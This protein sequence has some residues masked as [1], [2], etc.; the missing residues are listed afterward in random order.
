MKLFAVI[1]SQPPLCEFQL[2]IDGSEQIKSQYLCSM[3][4]VKQFDECI[5]H[6]RLQPQLKSRDNND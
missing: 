3:H 1:F 2:L 5:L 6:M 4:Y